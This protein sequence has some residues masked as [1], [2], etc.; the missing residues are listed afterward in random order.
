MRPIHFF[1]KISLRWLLLPALCFIFNGL[2]AQQLQLSDT[3]Y[4]CNGHQEPFGAI[5]AVIQTKDKGFAFVGNTL[6][7]G[8]GLI[9]KCTSLWRHAIFGKLDSN[10]DVVWINNLCDVGLNPKA[11]CETWDGGFAINAGPPST[12]PLGMLI[13]RYDKMGN[14]LWQKNYGRNAK[15]GTIQI[16]ATP[17]NGF[18]MLGVAGGIDSDILVNYQWPPITFQPLDW[19]LIKTDSLGNKQWVRTLG[20][21][22]DE[23]SSANIVVANN[24]FYLIGLTATKDHDCVDP[25]FPAP[26][27]YMYT[28]KLDTAGSVLWSRANFYGGFFNN[29]MFDDRDNSILIYGRTTGG[30]VYQTYSHG[31][32]DMFLIKMDT[33][34]NIIWAKLYGTTGNDEAFGIG[35]APNDGYFLAGD[36]YGTPAI[37]WGLLTV[38]DKSGNQIDQKVITG[39]GGVAFE[40][41]FPFQND[42]AAIG[43]TSSSKFNEGTGVNCPFGTRGTASMTLSRFILKDVAVANTPKKQELFSLSPNPAHQQFELQWQG[44]HPAGEIV[45]TNSLGQVIHRE[46]VV[47][48]LTQIKVSSANWLAGNYFVCW[49]ENGG[50]V[51]WKNVCV[52]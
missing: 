8:G 7:S 2:S 34:A 47:G 49:R 24:A 41:I 26:G 10:G 51:V 14:L 1:N 48:G 40:G 19:I 30:K 31:Y 50:A 15:S 32:D 22:G 6:D 17:D 18:L 42:F 52:W 16:I 23:G 38:V 11:I 20:T 21:S 4:Y 3:R 12:S 43:I 46:A 25:R 44:H 36:G 13:F 5:N 29:V 28:I 39:D 37:A 27:V 35:K 33:A 45:C 9:P